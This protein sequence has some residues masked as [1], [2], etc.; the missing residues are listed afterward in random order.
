M[1][2]ILM[3]LKGA[4]IIFFL[5]CFLSACDDDNNGD[6]SLDMQ[7]LNLDRNWIIAFY[8]GEDLV[9]TMDPLFLYFD[10]YYDD[11]LIYP[12]GRVDDPIARAEINDKQIDFYTLNDAG[13]GPFL[14]LSPEKHQLAGKL[15]S[16]I[17]VIARNIDYLDYADNGVP[18][19]PITI[20]D[21]LTDQD[22]PGLTPINPNT[23]IGGIEHLEAATNSRLPMGDNQDDSTPGDPVCT[24]S[25]GT[26]SDSC[27]G[28]K[29][30]GYRQCT[31]ASWNK[32]EIRQLSNVIAFLD[33]TEIF[34]GA[35]LQGKRFATGD[36][37]LV[38]AERTGGKIS[39]YGLSSHTGKLSVDIDVM[40]GDE[41]NERVAKMLRQLDGAQTPASD[42]YDTQEAY[43][44]KELK[45]NFGIDARYGGA[46]F[47]AS[48][49]ID[50]K[51]KTNT[52]VLKYTQIYY[53]LTY[54][55]PVGDASVV[56]KMNAD[57]GTNFNDYGTIGAD[58]PP[59]YVASV[60]YGRQIF[61]SMTSNQNM[62]DLKDSLN[63]AYNGEDGSFK[64]KSGLTYE[65]IM[66]ESE[67]SYVIR[68]SS[69]GL[70][71]QDISCNSGQS[72][73]ECIKALIADEKAA[74][75]SIDNPGVLIAYELRYLSD[76]SLAEMSYS[77]DY[78]SNDCI[79]I[80]KVDYSIVLKGSN[81][82]DDMWVWKDKETDSNKIYHTTDSH[83]KVTLSSHMGKKDEGTFILKLGNGGCFGTSGDFEVLIDGKRK[84]HKSFS[85]GC[86]D[87][88]WQLYAK[89][90]V[91][92]AKGSFEMIDFW[93]K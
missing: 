41:V 11:I 9:E 33:H 93:E 28:N 87:C 15:E 3:S 80:P 78:D 86:S 82:D 14:T 19:Q 30:E 71:A 47:G 59:L 42:G 12:A 66:D 39:V 57:N 54:D 72:M 68:G 37:S 1:K 31:P 60:Q 40:T 10:H 45:F 48:L 13:S 77:C 88:G 6:K 8:N 75:W 81:I 34:P 35:V 92:K 61:F 83:G 26:V 90:T 5:I 85:K 52:V 18:V 17:D 29:H 65:Q 27:P 91:D 76:R 56:F 32:S 36:F 67:M 89:F 58:N 79:E 70:V 4:F 64:A 63:A 23:N 46:E 55:I 62:D 22:E 74:S 24:D 20:D 44:Q 73:F 21:D 7:S 84:W 51:Q 25:D 49:K 2:N 50:Q 53:T 43:T 69:A 38:N 16:G